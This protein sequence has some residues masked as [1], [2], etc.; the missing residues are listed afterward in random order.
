MSPHSEIIDACLPVGRDLVT[1][2]RDLDGK[3]SM[4]EFSHE[5]YGSGACITHGDEIVC[6]IFPDRYANYQQIPWRMA[7]VKDYDS[8]VYGYL[9]T[10][11]YGMPYHIVFPTGEHFYAR[12]YA[13]AE[14]QSGTESIKGYHLCSGSLYA[15]RRIIAYRA[16]SRG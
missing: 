13:K 15:A 12:A 4:S 3:I 10:G 14:Y 2:D 16:L 1:Q 7:G 9:P 8:Y 6:A 11:Q 5:L